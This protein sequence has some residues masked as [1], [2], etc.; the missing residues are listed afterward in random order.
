MIASNLRELFFGSLRRRIGFV[1]T[2]LAAT[3][4]GRAKHYLEVIVSSFFTKSSFDIRSL[5][6]LPT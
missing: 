6:L 3:Y 5:L 4:V 2:W 1:A